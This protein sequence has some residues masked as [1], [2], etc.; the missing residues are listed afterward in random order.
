MD[1]TI[2]DKINHL[3]L[4]ISARLDESVRLAMD[5]SDG[6][7]FQRYRRAVG[8][9]LGEIYLEVLS[10]LYAQ[11]PSLVPKGLQKDG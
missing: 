10:P 11:H 1:R 6:E 8:K 5:N 2:A 7:E 3:M 4:D 9:I